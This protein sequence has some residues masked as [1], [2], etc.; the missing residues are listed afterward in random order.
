MTIDPDERLVFDHFVTGPANGVAAAAARRAAESPGSSYN[1]LVICG[2]SGAGKSH[3][4]SAVG[5]LAK[6][7][8]PDRRVHYDTIE[9]FVERLTRAIAEGRLDA[10]RQ[11]IAT[12]DL[13]LLDGL[14]EISGKARTQ[15]ELLLACETLVESGSQVVIASDRPPHE[16]PALDGR[17]LSWLATGLVVELGGREDA[18]R[19]QVDQAPDEFNDFL[20]DLTTAVAAVVETAPWK[21]RIARAIL[22]WESEGFR[23]RRL[24]QALDADSPPDVDALLAAFGREASRLREIQRELPTPPADPSLLDDPDR[25]GE[26]EQ[27][28]ATARSALTPPAAPERPSPPPREPRTTSMDS[29]FGDREKLA[30]SWAAAEDLLIE[31]PG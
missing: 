16:V 15:D 30:W 2:P 10:F 18:P 27:L 14:Q 21:R 23:T 12:A 8:E 6:S 31:E 13:L 4:L 3:L 19:A 5:H 17:L 24:E 20:S 26:A 25:L 7:N 29:W 11:A 22:R 28:F 9:T 1:P